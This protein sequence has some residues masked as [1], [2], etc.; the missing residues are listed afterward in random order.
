MIYS[1][2]AYTQQKQS[3]EH[4]NFSL[5]IRSV[6]HRY[7][8]LHLRIPDYFRAMESRI[9]EILGHHLARGKLDI[10]L[11]FLPSEAIG[12]LSLNLPL[13]KQLAEANEQ[14][15]ASFA[16]VD[17]MR[18]SD[19]LRWPGVVMETDV[20]ISLFAT[21]IDELFEKACQDLLATRTREGQAIKEF[22]IERT[23]IIEQEIKKLQ[24]RIPEI[25]TEL[26]TKMQ[27]RLAEVKENVD[28][29][30]FEQE[31]VMLLQKADIAEEI[32]RI[33]THINEVRRILN[34][35]GVCGRRLDFLMQELHRE[36]NTLGS[37]SI[38][39]AMSNCSVELKVSI[40]Q[41]REQVQNIE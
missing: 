24:S 15:L 28:P 9:R 40:D 8:E 41:M 13:V 20:D 4:G 6:N 38:D 3:N 7:L 39:V 11:N 14:V 37:K 22:L 25:N 17:S 33:D 26:R 10:T 29:S 31:I 21:T 18:T 35:G 12:K 19:V 27:K 32:N 2:T 23:E 36:A 5:E 30:R 34:K 16:K 1:M